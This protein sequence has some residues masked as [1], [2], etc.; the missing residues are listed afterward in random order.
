M[1]DDAIEE[2]LF[3]YLGGICIR[4]ECHVIKVGGYR[5]HVHVLCN[6]SKKL[7]L[8]KLMEELKGHSSKWIKTKGKAYKNFYWQGGYSAFSVYY[9]DVDVVVRYI[10]N[11]RTHH[12][13]KT[14]E[15]EYIT[16]L[17]EH[18]I[19]YDERYMWD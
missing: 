10:A 14:F 4:L 8:M 13:Q 6:L 5:N 7:P 2:E 18:D 19:P 15:E 17:K 9:R 1:I 3:A 12:T 11:Q 16:L